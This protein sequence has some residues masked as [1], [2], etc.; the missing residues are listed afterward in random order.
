MHP[1]ALADLSL[2]QYLHPAKRFKKFPWI[3]TY[4]FVGLDEL[5]GFDTD[6][7]PEMPQN[8]PGFAHTEPDSY[9]SAA[10]K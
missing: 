6:I 5:P 9:P 3:V 2:H 10:A 1:H 4:T 8:L 7:L